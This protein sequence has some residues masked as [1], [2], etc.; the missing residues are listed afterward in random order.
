MKKT[1]V[2]TGGHHTSALSIAKLLKK[3]G[4]QIAWVGHKYAA[5]NDKNLSGEYQ[6]VTKA[7]ID[8]HPL[9][10]GKFYKIK[11]PFEFIKIFLGLLQSFF[12]LI[13]TKPALIISFGGYLS[14]P[15]VIAG[16]GLGI[17][18][19]THEQT[20]VTGWATKA[21]SPFVKKILLTHPSSIN[22]R[23]KNKSTL[24]GLPLDKSFTASV[25]KKF[26]PPLL[27]ITAGKQGSHVVN[28]SIFPLIAELVKKYTIIHQTGSNSQFNDFNRAQR[29]KNNLPAYRQRYQPVRFL[30]EPQF[31]RLL[32]SARVVLSRSGAHTSYKLAL[33]KKPSILIPIPWV[34]HAEQQKNAQMTTK[35]A[36]TIILD[37]NKLSKELILSSLDKLKNKPQPKQKSTLPKNASQKIL[38]I[39][40]EY[41]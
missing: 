2:F 14:V 38:N 29:I 21:V 19:L 24:V 34:S 33:L 27:F 30:F 8:F 16:W 25:K 20:V 37:Q 35:Y 41:V 13:K 39:I 7:K 17:P 3:E 5:S 18:S 12:I 22:P 31:N 26:S 4:F 32:K 40:H 23:F 11:N 1:I 9:K 15:V 36:P 10:T 6:E 28:E